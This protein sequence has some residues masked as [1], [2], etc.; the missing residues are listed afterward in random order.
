[1]GLAARKMPPNPE[2]RFRD[3]IHDEVDKWVDL[4]IDE[5]FEDGKQLTVMELSELFAKTKKKFFGACL[6][7][8]IENRYTDLLEQEHAPCP[9]CA[10]V[11]KKRRDG[12]KEMVTH[13]GSQRFEAA[14]VLLCGLRI[15]IFADG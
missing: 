12:P 9:K 6:Q 15:W 13:A 7:T 10:K 8:L 11:C 14:L 2:E 1:M 3:M 5:A 4:I